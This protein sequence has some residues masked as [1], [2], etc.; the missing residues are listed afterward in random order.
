MISPET[1]LHRGEFLPAL[2]S[3]RS[4]GH[5]VATCRVLDNWESQFGFDRDMIERESREHRIGYV[6][7]NTKTPFDVARTPSLEKRALSGVRNRA[8][9]SPQYRRASSRL[10]RAP[11]SSPR[12]GP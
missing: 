5:V 3:L 1:V 6:L 9:S 11:R 4:C 12:P 10:R 8:T 7:M 2:K